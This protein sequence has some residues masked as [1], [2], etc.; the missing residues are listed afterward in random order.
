MLNESQYLS[1]KCKWCLTRQTP[2]EQIASRGV[3]SCISYQAV[4]IP[5]DCNC[6]TALTHNEMEDSTTEA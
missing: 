5:L 2:T 4:E 1:V 3:T 6:P